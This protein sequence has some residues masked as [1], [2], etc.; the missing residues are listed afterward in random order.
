MSNKFAAVA[1]SPIEHSL[2][3]LIHKAGYAALKIDWNYEKYELN[4]S[5]FPEFVK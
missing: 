3:P 5:T 4:A 2:S 1:G